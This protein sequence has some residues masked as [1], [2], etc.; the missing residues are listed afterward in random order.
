MKPMRLFPPATLHR[1]GFLQGGLAVGAGLSA[2]SWQR[3]A[4]AQTPG[5]KIAIGMI[6][7]G[8][9]AKAHFESM[10]KLPIFDVVA[11][12]DIDDKRM[13]EMAGKVEKQYGRA[14]QTYKDFRKLLENK[15]VAAVTIGTPDHWH[16]LNLIHACQAGKDAYVEKPLAHNVA[17]GRAMANAVA[18]SK[19]VVQV[20]TQQR[21][22]KHYQEVIELVRAGGLGR[23]VEVQ[24]W[25]HY[26]RAGMGK[27]ADAEVPAGVDYDMW[28]GPA[29]KRAFNPK[30]FHGSW[31]YFRDYGGGFV[32]DWNTHH[33][34]IVHL[35]L[36]VSSP[37]SAMMDGFVA[38]TDDM[39][40]MPDTAKAVW[41]YEAPQ[42][43]FTSTYSIRCTNSRSMDFNQKRADHGI[44]FYGQDATLVINREGYEIYPEKKAVPS[45]VVTGQTEMTAHF[46]DWAARI[47]DRGNP[48]S[49]VESV[50]KTTLVNHI[51]NI[52][53]LVGRK[54]Y[55]DAK[56]EKLFGDAKLKTPDREASALLMRKPRAPWKLPG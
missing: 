15:D 7:C 19:R 42:G 53:W 6:G 14:P 13:A 46:E 40:D 26:N 17:E 3:L 50:H 52:S 9:I 35:A 27:P 23:V 10:A 55:W 1:R 31:R 22:S 11:V 34:D 45:K 49:D 54:V 25:N 16:A 5:N 18:R 21:S 33:Q 43:R 37:Q 8:G 56:S 47:A 28:L 4:R 36:Q 24:T 30:R 39:R 20:G 51:A 41:E 38:M 29:P 32:T 12:C 2:L 48:R 44:A